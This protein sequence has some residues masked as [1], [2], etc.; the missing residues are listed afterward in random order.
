[1]NKKVIIIVIITLVLSTA[2]FALMTYTLWNFFQDNPPVQEQAKIELTTFDSESAFQ[3][4]LNNASEFTGSSY[5]LSP[6]TDSEKA[7][8]GTN[9]T[10]TSKRFSETNIQVEGVDE[11]DILKTDG[12][13]IYYSH[14]DIFITD[15][16]S[17]VKPDVYPGPS[18]QPFSTEIIK[19]YPPEQLASIGSI[20]ESGN[21]YYAEKENNLIVIN[22][23]GIFAY[24]LDSSLDEASWDLKP[25]QE[26][27]I[28]ETRYSDDKL[29]VITVKYLNKN[30]P[31]VVPL[32]GNSASEKVYDIKCSSIYYTPD[33]YSNNG[34]ISVFQIDPKDGAILKSI[35]IVGTTFNS[36]VYMSNESVYLTYAQDMTDLEIRL[37]F[38][39]SVSDLFPE[40]VNKDISRILSYD[41]SEESQ[42][43]EIQLILDK[44]NNTLTEEEQTDLESM[45]YTEMANFVTENQRTFYRTG[46]A[47]ISIEDLDLKATAKV[48]G[49]ILNQF[50]IDEYNE[51]LRVA[52]TVPQ[53]S[54]GNIGN[55]S[56][57]PTND[58]Y[59]LNSR[60]VTIGEV[61]DIGKGE[62]IYST[63]F[64]G[65]TAYVVTYKQI[66]PFFVF[67]LSNPES[68]QKVGELK[69]PGF[70]SYLHILPDNKVLGI[71]QESIGNVKIS[72]FD[73][74][75]KS[76]PIEIDKYI[77]PNSWSEVSNNHHAFL[78]DSKHQVFFLP[79]GGKGYVISY[80]NSSLSTK[81]TIDE[82]SN[83]RALYINNTMYIV[84]ESAVRAYNE[85]DW[86]EIN[87]LT[88][89]KL[90]KEGPLV[91]ITPLEPEIPVEL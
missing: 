29:Y 73:V 14:P 19:A 37:Q 75:D 84:T 4:F 7:F 68:P 80:A 78:L 69:I 65:N 54:L 26:T 12:E 22:S 8:A 90:L 24:N 71:G 49:R 30:T 85:N 61:K 2:L 79:A 47:K 63:R 21:L 40:S 56:G 15:K 42:D 51:N 59:I 76:K 17:L 9:E 18:Y 53:F 43:R 48:P 16:L 6:A 45:L 55:P 28:L 1:M 77:I 27:S 3:A 33:N 36:T 82:A 31:C 57:E 41:I 10:I 32:L 67:D 34:L 64:T 39:K 58:L 44:Y 72:L 52:T 13:N 35:S 50:S 20:R 89:E 83:S 60:L 38:L 5:S 88:F 25:E 87:S 86:S 70:S 62:Q 23:Q 74:S 91:P 46:F 81:K 11:A 66:D